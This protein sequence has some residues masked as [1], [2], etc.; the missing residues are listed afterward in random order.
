V[1]AI[2]D[3]F[4]WASTAPKLLCVVLALCLMTVSTYGFWRLH[5]PALNASSETFYARQGVLKLLTLLLA[6][7]LAELY[8]LVTEYQVCG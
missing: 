7:S 2:T 3:E 5:V 4:H 6:L 8:Y 1:D